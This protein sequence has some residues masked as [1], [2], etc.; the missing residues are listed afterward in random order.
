MLR[1]FQRLVVA[2]V[3]SAAQGW[4]LS[5]LAPSP[6]ARARVVASAIWLALPLVLRP[7]RLALPLAVHGRLVRLHVEDA[8]D[9]AVAQE[10]LVGGEYEVPGLDDV[11]VIVDLGSHIGTSIL[12]FR[13]RYPEARIYGFEPDPATFAKLEANV[14][15][16][17][18]VTVQRRAVAG[19]DGESVLHAASY[20]LRS[21]LV[22]GWSESSAV[23]VPAA[24][25]DRV[26]EE[27]GLDRIDLLKLDI[28]GS[29]TE[30]LAG[31]EA[32]GRVRAI[33]GELH[34]QL[35]D[36]DAFLALLGD[37]DVRVH[38]LS[39][40]SWHFQAVRRGG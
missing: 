35:T 25:L 39:D 29:E 17:A 8:A 38:K 19:A 36:P 2:L 18:G 22:A 6:A 10:V 34:P 31:A 1:R 20:S 27:L 7:R 37:F 12:F 5:A 4:R 15:A 21:S 14:G 13:A 23:T 30:A 26:V 32:L 28:E 24:R 16:L 40:R 11:E 3:R 33:A 9:L